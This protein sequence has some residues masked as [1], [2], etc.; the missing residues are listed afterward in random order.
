M[1]NLEKIKKAQELLAEAHKILANVQMKDEEK[2]E[3]QRE[4]LSDI[5]E[6]Y[7]KIRTN[8]NTSIWGEVEIGENEMKN[9]L[10]VSNLMQVYYDNGF[11]ELEFEVDGEQIIITNVKE[12]HHPDAWEDEWYFENEEVLK[13]I[14]INANDEDIKEVK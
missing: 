2:N 10:N 3:A 9:K 6:V 5:N 12:E 4:V 11:Y 13:E 14:L 1:T 8:F 7:K